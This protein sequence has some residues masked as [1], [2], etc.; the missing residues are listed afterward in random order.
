MRLATCCG[1][2][3]VVGL[4]LSFVSVLRAD[5]PPNVVA[6][7]AAAPG[8]THDGLSWDGAYLYLQDALQHAAD[9]GGTITEIWVA[10]GTYYP[11]RGGEQ[12]LEDRGAT[13]Q[14]LSGV[15][16]HGG[17]AGAANPGDPNDRQITVY[18]TILIGDLR[19]DDDCEVSDPPASDCCQA[20]PG[21]GGCD[22][23]WCRGLVCAEDGK[24]C[25]DDPQNQFWGWGQGCVTL[26][27]QLCRCVCFEG[28]NQ[29][30]SFHV[31]TASGTDAT[32][33]LDGFTITWGNADGTTD[34]SKRGAGLYIGSGSP[35]ISNCKIEHNVASDAGG[36]VYV[37][38]GSPAFLD[39]DFTYNVAGTWGGAV[40]V[41][42][43]GL[44]LTRCDFDQ[45]TAINDGGGVH[46]SGGSTTVID[47]NFTVNHT[48]DNGG[49]I[50]VTSGSVGVTNCTFSFNTA[51]DAGGGLALYGS[52]S[53][54]LTG[55]T[56]TQNIVGP[57]SAQGGAV[58]LYDDCDLDAIHCTFTGGLGSNGGAIA[59][60]LNS[61][62]ELSDCTIEDGQV[63][64]AGGGLWL[65]DNC[66][67]TLTDCTIHGNEALGFGGGAIYLAYSSAVTINGGE[68]T[69]NVASGPVSVGGGISTFKQNTMPSEIIVRNCLIA[70]NFAVVGGGAILAQKA[71]T[72]EIS[73]CTIENNG[74][75]GSEVT[76]NGGAIQCG[77]YSDGSHTITN[78]EI[79]NNQA[80]NFG[81]GIFVMHAYLWTGVTIDGCII[82]GNSAIGGAGAVG[83]GGGIYAGADPGINPEHTYVTVS[84]CEIVGNQAAGYG[85]GMFVYGIAE[86]FP[87]ETTVTDTLIAQNTAGA[88]G[89]GILHHAGTAELR[90]CTIVDNR[91]TTGNGGGFWKGVH[92]ST[93]HNS[94][95]WGNTA[96][97]AGQQMLVPAT[98]TT[99]SYSD[100]QGCGGSDPDNW[101]D[102]LG[103]D[104]G[105]NIDDDPLFI[106]P[107]GADGDPD[108]D[109]MLDPDALPNRSPCIDA[110]DNSVIGHL[111]VDLVGNPRIV[112]CLVDMGAYETQE[113]GP[114]WE[115]PGDP[116][117][118]VVVG[119]PRVPLEFE[120]EVYS[121]YKFLYDPYISLWDS[122]TGGNAIN[123]NTTYDAQE[124]EAGCELDLVGFLALQRCFTADGGG[125]AGQGRDGFDSESDYDVDLTDFAAFYPAGTGPVCNTIPV[126]VQ[127]VN[128]SATLGDAAIT[129]QVMPEGETEFY[130]QATQLVTAASIQIAPTSGGIGTPLT[131]TLSPAIPPL[132]FN[133]GTTAEWDG[134]YDPVIGDPTDPF[135]VVYGTHQ[136]R[137]LSA[138]QATIVV[139]NGAVT[140][141]PSVTELS[142]LGSVN[143]TFTFNLSGLTVQRYHT[144]G[145]DVGDA[146]KWEIVDYVS[147]QVDPVIAGEAPVLHVLDVS[148]MSDPL[149]PSEVLLYGATAFHIAAVVRIEGTENL[150]DPCDDPPESILVD[151][152]SF[153]TAGNSEVDRVCGLTL[154]R[155]PGDDGDPDH[156]VYHNDL[157][158]PIVLVDVDLPETQYPNVVPFYVVDGGSAMIAACIQ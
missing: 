126:Y 131:I 147:G 113:D 73:G 96:G 110:G 82:E 34:E 22:D 83:D 38:G 20:R 89:G 39:S 157:N 69:Q 19:A 122:L 90:N 7:D 68:M 4:S 134:V 37:A 62:A 74:V 151:L 129:L 93:I 143:G 17:Y 50:S 54:T 85:G 119:E 112:D 6:V 71:D 61:S 15:S 109:Y 24:C 127:A 91:A 47:S 16:I 105:G 111:A 64:A 102:L 146:G 158:K 80:K 10:G 60:S 3:F 42:D 94:I 150:E 31:V 44:T 133:A 43:G 2:V 18:E 142:G 40:Y 45:N 138:S 28:D 86:A 87:F 52:A 27:Y 8:T 48:D 41:E 156:F 25:V 100:I 117:L 144:L 57:G 125:P 154:T 135:Q 23:S 79:R 116:G 155:V 59:L 88:D 35:T 67:A 145:L 107:T 92:A 53:A 49:A 115:E 51:G 14:L 76:V 132:A 153:N 120:V 46:A 137:E 13:F 140:D 98:D 77:G 78:T 139:G 97:G 128:P 118:V 136:F 30:N 121:Q 141:A 65:Y 33:V 32:A 5:L 108:N 26:A 56:F 103:T 75:N 81:G 148:N 12:T 21:V 149:N 152:I 70:G 72:L 58:S 66:S 63:V 101:D 1:G 123:P 84:R 9:S 29:E 104:G 99:V 11:D 130:D 36:G 55:S 95:L 124:P 114:G 106:D